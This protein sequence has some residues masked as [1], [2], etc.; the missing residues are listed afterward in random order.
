MSLYAI[1]GV[2]VEAGDD[3]SAFAN[4]VARETWKRS[5]F[6]RIHDLSK[7]HFRGPMM[8][9]PSDK[10]P[11][12]CGFDF[13]PDG[14]GTKVT[15][16][17][18]ALSHRQAA[19]DVLAMTAGDITRYGGLPVAFSNVLDVKKLGD[20]G[21]PS[22]QAFEQLILGLA[23]VALEQGIVLYR[24]ET[25]ELGDCV[26]SENPD[27]VTHFNWAGF[28][29]GLHHPDKVI[30]GERLRPGQPIIAIREDGFR[31]NGMSTVRKALRMKFG[32]EYDGK[33]WENPKARSSIRAAAT[34]S[35]LPDRFLAKANGWYD[36][37]FKARIPIVAIANITGGGIPGKFG[38]D[39]LFPMGLSA[40][41]PNL[42]NPPP[43][44]LDCAEWRGFANSEEIYDTLGGGQ[45]ML[46]V[47]ENKRDVKP[48]IEMATH[49]N[50]Y[51][52]PAGNI[53]GNDGTGS[54]L[55]IDSK[56]D[57]TEVTYRPK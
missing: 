41:L 47:L 44:M 56:F 23:D 32:A 33:W 13:A 30:T 39:I 12:G 54:A 21:T 36:R 11:K 38:K 22:R 15:I 27:A 3:F 4:R 6:V 18:E 50:L 24:G 8:L 28:A 9:L 14:V 25:A 19:R 55:R 31:S 51:A 7:G 46:V 16:I 37:D 20:P 57:G 17:S 2:D 26:S 10:M 49:D 52:Q 45:C 1:D 53:E 34:P 35:V 40:D 5:P 48:F 43:V 42:C 29:I